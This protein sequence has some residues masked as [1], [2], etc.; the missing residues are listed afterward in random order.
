MQKTNASCT[1]QRCQNTACALMPVHRRYYL[2]GNL[3]CY[4]DGPGKKSREQA[5]VYEMLGVR[6]HRLDDDASGSVQ[7]LYCTD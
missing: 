7:N 3:L 2:V 4:S 1:I 6:C 5:A